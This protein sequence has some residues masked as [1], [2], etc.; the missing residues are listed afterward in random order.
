MAKAKD[1]PELMATNEQQ[2]PQRLNLAS[3]AAG[4][5]QTL[6]NTLADLKVLAD[7]R[8][9]L[10]N[11]EDADFVG[12]DLSYMDA[13]TIGSFFD[14]VVPSLVDNFNDAANGGRNKQ[15]TNQI[16]KAV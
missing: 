15:I 14:F 9:Y 16:A 3:S 7:R 1:A 5:A 6:I 11:F 12:T 10:G 8:P 4:L 2:K 13:G